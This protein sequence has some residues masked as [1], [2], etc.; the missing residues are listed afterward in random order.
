MS[1]PGDPRAELGARDDSRRLRLRAFLGLANL[2]V[3][4]A[5]L[6]FLSAGTVRFWQ[7]WAYWGVFSAA[8][9]LITL[10][11]L[12]HDPGLVGRRMHAG[13]VAEREPS[14]RLIQGLAG[15]LFCAMFVV[16]GIER[17]FR[18][19]A[20]PPL[21]AL[22]AD[23][24]VAAGFAIVHFVFRENGHAS[25]VI[26]VEPGQRVVSTGPYALV[27]HPMYA[28]AMLMI[29]AT[30]LALGSIWALACALPLC[31]AVVARLLDE[32]RYLAANLQGYEEY[33]RKVRC[34]LIPRVW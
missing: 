5:L 21:A 22:G 7:A 13:P 23:V 18:P 16:P 28:G 4:I 32:E 33:L 6:L 12:R 15:L 29:L 26:E 31:G 17:R 2:Q 30:P 25:S 10:Y 1:G 3:A 34:R 14:Q 11:L 9:L 24:L 19:S 20:L 27:R 8:V